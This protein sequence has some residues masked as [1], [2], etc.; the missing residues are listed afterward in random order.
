MCKSPGPLRAVLDKLGLMNSLVRPVEE[1]TT[2]GAE[3]EIK[4]YFLRSQE[5]SI[6]VGGRQE[7]SLLQCSLEKAHKILMT[8]VREAWMQVDVV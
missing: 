3:E 7:G 4:M 1:E 5:K 6:Q 2:S 8:S